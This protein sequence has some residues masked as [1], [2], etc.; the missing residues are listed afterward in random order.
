MKINLNLTKSEA[1]SLASICRS[2]QP[3]D[4]A[5]KT[6]QAREFK[7]CKMVVEAINKA[8]KSTIDKRLNRV[9]GITTNKKEG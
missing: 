5:S 8:Q 9:F 7:V 4:I 2:Y 3:S 6:E 1:E